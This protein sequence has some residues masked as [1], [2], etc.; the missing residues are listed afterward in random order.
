MQEL[1]NIYSEQQLFSIF[2][3]YKDSNKLVL[4]KFYIDSCRYCQDLDRT[5]LS[6]EEKEKK[7]LVI[8]AVDANKLPNLLKK[9]P[10]QVNCFPTLFL[11]HRNI[12]KK[13]IGSLTKE[14]LQSFLICI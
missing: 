6:L 13:A 7:E 4:V 5:I 14:Q 9:E 8:L 12:K 3:E 11:F 1:I 10:F 2:S